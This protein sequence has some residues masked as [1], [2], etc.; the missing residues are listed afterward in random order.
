[1]RNNGTGDTAAGSS[2][3][4]G[5]GGL[6]V[7]GVSKSFDTVRGERFVALRDVNL[8]VRPEEFV[9][10]VGPSGCGKSTLLAMIAGL[11]PPS[12][13]EIRAGGQLVTGPSPER[14][15]VFQ[16]S[17]VLPWRRALE[18]V[19]FGLE[20]AGSGTA[21]ERRATAQHYL[22]LVGLTGFEAYYPKELSGGMRQRLAIAQTLAC[23]PRILLMDEPFGAL[24]AFT[25]DVL[26]TV[27]LDI[28]E[29]ERKTV[30][31][32]THSVDE[33][34]YLSDRI[35]VMGSRPGRVAE[36]IEVDLPRPRSTE[37]RG[38][39]GFGHARSRVWDSLDAAQRAAA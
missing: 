13:G 33:A 31:F 37:V 38:S 22:G 3:H 1:M 6:A 15:V 26:Q 34:V 29:A 24:D 28:W 30:C 17:S 32:V 14:G 36:V 7:H 4:T 23:D 8:E 25:R 18:N 12:T 27:L 2:G 5:A 16:E 9:S 39:T 10:L 21:R 20:L 11:V 19:T 35:V